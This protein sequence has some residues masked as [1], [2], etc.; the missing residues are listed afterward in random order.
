MPDRDPLP[1]GLEHGLIGIVQTISPSRVNT[2]AS[3][4]NRVAVAEDASL[5][6][7]SGVLMIVRMQQP[8]PEAGVAL[9]FGGAVPR[10][11]STW[12]R[13][14]LLPVFGLLGVV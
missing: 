11:S 10:I 5:S 13:H 14:R 4:G 7:D 2:S 6:I 8:R 3:T 1:V 9:D 12:G